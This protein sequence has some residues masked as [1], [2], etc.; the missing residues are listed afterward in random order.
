MPR[1]ERSTMALKL[2]LK[3]NERVI[4]GDAVVKNGG[5]SP[6]HLIIENQVPIL[7]RK[8]LL[9]EEE[10]N[11]HC[12]RIYLAVQLM[13]VDEANLKTYHGMYWKLVRELVA[14]V[15]SALG[16]VDRISEKILG[17]QYYRALKL[18]GELIDYE[19]ELL[20]HAKSA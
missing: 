16:Y 12:K 3:P 11:T 14:A 7:R 15:P 2:T 8:D 13:Y 18:A 9:T 10:A 5:K 1:N 4:L 6:C 19:K 20:D 17:G